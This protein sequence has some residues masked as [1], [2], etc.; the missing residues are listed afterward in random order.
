MPYLYQLTL[1]AATRMSKQRDNNVQSLKHQGARLLFSDH[2][3][4]ARIWADEITAVGIGTY[5]PQYVVPTNVLEDFRRYDM[6]SLVHCTPKLKINRA[7]VEDAILIPDVQQP[8]FIPPTFSWSYTKLTDFE[9]CP[10]SFAEKNYYKRI[11]FTQTEQ[12]L[13]GIRAHTALEVY[14]KEGRT[15]DELRVKHALPLVDAIRDKGGIILVE[16]QIAVDRQFKITEWF[17]KQAWGRG[18]IDLASIREERALILDWKTGKKKHDE[19]QLKIF[20]LFL[21]FKYPQIQEFDAKFG[22]LREQNL[23][24]MITGFDKPLRRVDLKEP[25]NNLIG[26]IKRMEDAWQSEIFQARTSGLCKNYCDVM[27]CGHNGRKP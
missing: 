1:E 7:E 11:K 3:S 14:A 5:G 2:E 26:R 8:A 23:K 17:G 4:I 10:M 24:D 22:W 12:M 18:V 25:L 6:T 15:S 9:N 19:L 13:D 27:G 16:E 20:C 21:A